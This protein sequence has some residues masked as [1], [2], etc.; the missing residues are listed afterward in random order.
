MEKRYFVRSDTA[1]GCTS[2]AGLAARV[3]VVSAQTGEQAGSNH[4][5]RGGFLFSFP[6]TPSPDNRQPLRGQNRNDMMEIQIKRFPHAEGLALP[7]YMTDGAVA[8]DLPAAIPQGEDVVIEHYHL[9]GWTCG[10][11]DGSVRPDGVA[12][13]L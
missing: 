4:G 13:W 7:Q 6:S 9:A 10:T 11:R 5:L 8:C 1:T 3:V 12:G 2:R